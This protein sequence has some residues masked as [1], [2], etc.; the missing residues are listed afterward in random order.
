MTQGNNQSFSISPSGGYTI[1]SVTVDGG[2]VGN[3]SSYTFSNVQG[4][5]TISA[6]FTPSNAAPSAPVISGPTSGNANTSYTFSVNSTDPQGNQIRY[7]IDWTEPAD[8]VAD[9]WLP[10]GVNYVNSGTSQSTTHSW[11]SSG[12]H[13]FRALAQDA[14]GLNSSWSS[15]SFTVSSCTPTYFCS[16]NDLYYRNASCVESLSQT[17][18]YGCAG[19]ACIPPPSIGFT[20]FSASNVTYGPFTATGHLEVKPSLLWSGNTTSVYWNVSNAQSCSVTGSNGDS[21]SG[22]FSGSGGKTSSPITSQ[23]TYTLACTG[24][25]GATPISVIETVTVN[26]IPVFEEK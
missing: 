5:H 25:P 22:S 2:N 12:T 23:T 19:S 6:S 18:G 1:A 20:P 16:G 7:G 4:G 24:F 15:Y 10:A 14:P 13:T 26:I 8:G 3:V 21:W 11:S 17:C 9:V